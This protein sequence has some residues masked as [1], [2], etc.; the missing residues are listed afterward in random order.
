[1]CSRIFSR[2]RWCAR[3]VTSPNQ[4]G[5]EGTDCTEVWIFTGE[6]AIVGIS[7]PSQ[8]NFIKVLAA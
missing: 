6:E 5:I 7:P 4:P 1:M 8:G 3:R 2:F